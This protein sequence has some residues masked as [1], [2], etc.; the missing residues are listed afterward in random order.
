MRKS[1]ARGRLIFACVWLGIFAVSYIVWAFYLSS[2]T[3]RLAEYEALH[4]EHE[5][6]RVFTEY[7]LEA[8]PMKFSTYDA[9]V[10]SKYDI[11]GS[12]AKFF[13]DLTYGKVLSLAEL[14]REVDGTRTYAVCAD[15]SEFARIVLIKEKSEAYSYDV[16]SLSE[17]ILTARPAYELRITAPKAA[18][19]VLNG[20]LLDSGYAVSEYMLADSPCFEGNDAARVMVEYKISGLYAEP[21]VSVSLTEAGVQ[22]GLDR[23]DASNHTSDRSYVSYISYLYYGK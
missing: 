7:F 12:S 20:V 23:E 3:S 6:E 1:I 11:S 10:E 14:A 8:D 19:V 21:D 5:A 2:V 13:S 9:D 18:A 15:G 17:I 22:L 4:P 16:W